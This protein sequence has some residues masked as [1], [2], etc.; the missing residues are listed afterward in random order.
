ME[1]AN[2]TGAVFPRG[3]P[4]AGIGMAAIPEEIEILL[5]PSM[6]LARRNNGLMVVGVLVI[7]G[8]DLK[9]ATVE[10]VHRRRRR[11]TPLRGAVGSAA[12]SNHLQQFT[13]SS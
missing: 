6:L 4:L 5:F 10:D 11:C 7:K 13:R 8:M 1:D 2:T 12:G 9:I 3:S